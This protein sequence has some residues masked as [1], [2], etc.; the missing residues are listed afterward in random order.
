MTGHELT[1]AHYAQTA[2]S[3]MKTVA[4]SCTPVSSRSLLLLC[5]INKKRL[6]FHRG[7]R[8]TPMSSPTYRTTPMPNPLLAAA[9]DQCLGS[10][11]ARQ[12]EEE[13]I[14]L[15][16]HSKEPCDCYK[17]D[18]R[19]I[20]ESRWKGMKRGEVGWWYLIVAS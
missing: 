10:A 4:S 18:C 7:I 2:M 17:A 1:I 12:K 19:Y 3:V 20:S 6:V 15:L 13:A 11:Y 8:F 5:T 16:L 9:V 14:R